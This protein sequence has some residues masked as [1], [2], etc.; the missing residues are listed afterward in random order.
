MSRHAPGGTRPPPRPSWPGGVELSADRPSHREWFTHSDADL[1]D[2]FG[3]P[4]DV[5]LDRC[6]GSA[7]Y[8][9]VLRVGME[10]A[11]G[12]GKGGR[13]AS[14]GREEDKEGTTDHS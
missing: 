6:D 14:A 2:G 11:V 3:H 9:W 5:E 4:E 8:V 1:H 10:G 12:G 13:N 7:R